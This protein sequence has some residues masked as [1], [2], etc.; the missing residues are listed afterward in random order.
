ML[1]LSLGYGLLSVFSAAAHADR[2]D[3]CRYDPRP[4]ITF[5][6]FASLDLAQQPPAPITI[7]GKLQQP[8]KWQHRKKCF[9]PKRDAAAVLILH[10]TAGVDSRGD[11][12]AQALNTMGIATLEIDMWEAR[13]VTGVANRPPLPLFT[14][15][16]AFGALAYLSAHPGIAPNRIGV[17]GFSW[18]AVVTMAAATEGI[19][20][21]FGGPLRFKAH[22]AHYP[23]CYAYNNPNIPGSNLGENAGNPLTG[24]PI[25][26]QIGTE[27]AYDEGA[28]PCFAL[29]A[30]LVPAEQ[31]KLEVMAYDGAF[32]AWDRLQ[33]PIT[34]V[35]PFS[36][37]GAG[38]TVEIAPSVEQAYE[39]RKRAV[40]HFLRNL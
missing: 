28:E 8:V 10:G 15:P 5:I 11:F 9:L 39:A 27:D 3:D 6:E 23:L 25:L 29:R 4:V 12:Y 34:A 30:S 22:V 19:A 7:K 35:D 20:A 16:D 13:G 31:D 26:I 38:G 36:H 33:V 24:A 32:H 14:Y 21:Q 17:L 37:L 1:I 2:D 18:G 40:Q